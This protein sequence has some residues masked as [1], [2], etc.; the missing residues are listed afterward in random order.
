MFQNIFSNPGTS[1]PS[2]TEA[3]STVQT[4]VAS[5]LAHNGYIAA[6]RG[7]AKDVEEEEQALRR[8]FVNTNNGLSPNGS[9]RLEE[10]E[11]KDVSR[12]QRI[13]SDLT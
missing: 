6:A 13:S 8:G 3:I 5:Y 2:D 9:S 1:E 11:E 4:L 10:V 12:R 7:F